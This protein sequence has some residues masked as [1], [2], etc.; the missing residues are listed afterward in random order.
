[1]TNIDRKVLDS[2][3][4]ILMPN[5]MLP[6][7][8]SL[9]VD[10]SINTISFS[11]MDYETIQEYLRQIDRT[12][13]NYFYQENLADFNFHYKN[14]PV[15]FFP[16]PESFQEI[17]TAPCRWPCFSLNSPVHIYVERL[18]QRSTG[19]CQDREG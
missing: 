12:C 6:R 16:I 7:L 2:Y 14:Y 9:S 10:F 19:T 5:F 17:L 11:E 18:Y 1:M 8:E 4:I 13:R 3:D 15:D